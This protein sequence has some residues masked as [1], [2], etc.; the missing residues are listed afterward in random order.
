MPMPV[1]TIHSHSWGSGV[2]ASRWVMRNRPTV[3]MARAA[4]MSHLYGPCG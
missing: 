4:V 2:S 1:M 3:M